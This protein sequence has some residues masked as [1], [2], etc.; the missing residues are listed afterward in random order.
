MMKIFRKYCFVLS[1]VMILQVILYF[2]GN[3]YEFNF[4][5][6]LSDVSAFWY[7]FVSRFMHY[8]FLFC[9]LNILVIGIMGVVSLFQRK[10]IPTG[11]FFLMAS[12][13]YLYYFFQVARDF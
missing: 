2:L 6:W 1:V 11:F 4:Y 9:T 10:T 8:L 5:E 3:F 7:A 12:L 13:L